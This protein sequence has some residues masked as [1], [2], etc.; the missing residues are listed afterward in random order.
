MNTLRLNKD[1]QLAA[2]IFNVPYFE[3]TERQIASIRSDSYPIAHRNLIW[4]IA[5]FHPEFGP[6]LP[7]VEYG[8][9]L[10]P[11]YSFWLVPGGTGS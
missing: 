4:G 6:A 1:R 7:A 3:V 9:P 11:S 8:H 5:R 2:A 10:W